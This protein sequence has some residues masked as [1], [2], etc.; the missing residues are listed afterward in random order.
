MYQAAITVPEIYTLYITDLSSRHSYFY[1]F[2]LG[3]VEISG[4]FEA[5]LSHY[6]AMLVLKIRTQAATKNS[7]Y[8]LHC[9]HLICLIFFLVIIIPGIIPYFPPAL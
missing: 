5:G 8:P 9:L 2:F 7:L 6:L 3:L 4:I 1:I